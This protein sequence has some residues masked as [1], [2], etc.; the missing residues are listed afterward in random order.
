MIIC[1][2]VPE[3]WHLT[4]EIVSFHFGLPLNS[5]KNKNFK[6]IM[7]KNTWRYHHFTQL[8]QKS[9]SY[10]ILFRRYGVW[11]SNCYF[12]FWAIFCPFTPLTPQKNQNFKKMKKLMELSSFNTCV[13]KKM[14]RWCMVP[15]KWYATDRQMDIWT[16][17]VTYRDGCP[18]LRNQYFEQSAT[19]FGMKQKENC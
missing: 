11:Q 14:I 2:I 15:E 6:K 12:S 7:K 5:P 18:T 16:E 17:K 9:W 8:Y 3:I 4:D 10:A 13:P 19:L 1:F